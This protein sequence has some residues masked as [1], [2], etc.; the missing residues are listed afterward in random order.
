MST[1]I[2]Q[3]IE[4]ILQYKLDLLKLSPKIPK[5]VISC[6]PYRSLTMEDI[7]TPED[8][9]PFYCPFPFDEDEPLPNPI[10]PGWVKIT[11]PSYI[12]FSKR[13]KIT[14]LYSRQKST[15]IDNIRTRRYID[16]REDECPICCEPI[17]HKHTAYITNCGHRFHYGCFQQ[18]EY[19]DLNKVGECPICRQS[20]GDS[21]YPLKLRYEFSGNGLDRLEDFWFNFGTIYPVICFKSDDYSERF[22]AQHVYGMD[23]NCI[24]CVNYRKGKKHPSWYYRL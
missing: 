2:N 15:T 18:C 19:I 14:G 13:D 8:D 12:S 5:H 16:P 7:V 17:I 4:K 23:S 21:P 6:K 9:R 22:Y 11:K 10:M 24:D 1:T 3:K 20:V